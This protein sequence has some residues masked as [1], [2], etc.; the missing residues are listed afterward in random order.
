M[1]EEV[2]IQLMQCAML[3]TTVNC[4]HTVQRTLKEKPV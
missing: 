4:N 2:K 1:S 3:T